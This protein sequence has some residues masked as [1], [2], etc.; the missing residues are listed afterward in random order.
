MRRELVRA[1]HFVV[2][3]AI[4]SRLPRSASR[5]G[6]AWRSLR[7]WNCRHLFP[8]CGEGVNIE[9]G[10]KFGSGRWVRIG[11]RSGIGVNAEILGPVR[12]GHDVMMAPDVLIMTQ[13]HVIADT[14]L[15]MAKQGLTDHRPVEIGDDVW[16]GSRAIILPGVKVGSGA[17]IAA[18]AVVSK[19]VSELSIVGG[20]PAVPIGS[21]E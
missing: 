9:R 6:R 11:D 7:L 13:N 15:P 20:V 5:G 18:G 17:V 4:T 3:S 10:A 2:Y 16:I 1:F 19:N 8:E 12:I 14:S 21:R